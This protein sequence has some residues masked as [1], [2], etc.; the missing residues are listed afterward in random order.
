[1]KVLYSAVQEGNSARF[2]RSLMMMVMGV[3]N[4]NLF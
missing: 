1:M 4:M 3:V 2:L